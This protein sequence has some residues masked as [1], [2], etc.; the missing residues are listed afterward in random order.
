MQPQPQMQTQTQMQTQMQT[1]TQKKLAIN[2]ILD[3]DVFAIFEAS[4][5][6]LYSANGA[7]SYLNVQIFALIVQR[8]SKI[9]K[10]LLKDQKL[11]KYTVDASVSSQTR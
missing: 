4:S 9:S 11:K 5:L 2:N 10:Q 1:Q 8:S 6:T 3:F 7:G